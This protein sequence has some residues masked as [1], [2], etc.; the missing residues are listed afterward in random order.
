[1]QLRNVSSKLLVISWLTSSP[2]STQAS[3]RERLIT[4]ECKEVLS[5][6]HNEMARKD[7]ETP[8]VG[9]SDD[10]SASR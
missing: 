10:A 8:N 4:K 3:E 5:R 7:T 6:V 1:M 9:N 2:L